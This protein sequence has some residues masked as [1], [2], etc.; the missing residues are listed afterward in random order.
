MFETAK[1]VLEVRHNVNVVAGWISPVSDGYGKKG[2]G[3]GQCGD[4]TMYF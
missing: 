4:L 2:L 3:G 1:G